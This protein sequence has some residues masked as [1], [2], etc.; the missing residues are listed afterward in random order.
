[1]HLRALGDSDSTRAD[2]NSPR[3]KI[4]LP[5][6]AWLD[7]ADIPPETELPGGKLTG[8][9]NGY[10]P[11]EDADDAV[12]QQGLAAWHRL[13]RSPSLE[14]WRAVGRA[15]GVGRRQCLAAIGTDEARGSRKYPQLMTSWLKDQGLDA[16]SA[17][18]RKAA[19]LLDMHWPEIEEWL[20]TL[21]PNK[22]AKQNYAQVVWRNF[23]TRGRKPS[24]KGTTWRNRQA[25]TELQVAQAIDAVTKTLPSNDPRTVAMAC[26]RAAGFAIPRPTIA[27]TH[28]RSAPVEL[29][30]A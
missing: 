21:S 11:V 22:R 3:L 13:Q 29:R 17:T 19:L 15:L 26:L 18:A 9:M 23:Q 7:R 30:P 14:D 4:S 2:P 20:D 25:L 5:R 8:R 6:V 24:R 27:P 16:I 12:I 10:D 1:M 28:H